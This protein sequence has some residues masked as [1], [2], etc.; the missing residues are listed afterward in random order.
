M[1]QGFGLVGVI[2]YVVNSLLL[3][4]ECFQLRVFFQYYRS[5]THEGIAYF[6]IAYS[7][8]NEQVCK[9]ASI[10]DLHTIVWQRHVASLETEGVSRL[11]CS[12]SISSTSTKYLFKVVSIVCK[13]PT[14]YQLFHLISPQ[15]HIN[16]FPLHSQ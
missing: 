3:V 8:L 1:K 13:F 11:A 10:L 15:N 7:V 4:H 14:T 12:R 5:Q 6:S 2:V 16:M 9:V